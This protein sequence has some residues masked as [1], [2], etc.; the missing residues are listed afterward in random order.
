M[1]NTDVKLIINVLVLAFVCS[2][3]VAEPPVQTFTLNNFL[4]A[5]NENAPGYGFTYQSEC[6]S[7]G[8]APD[9]TIYFDWWYSFYLENNSTDHAIVSWNWIEIIS[10]TSWWEGPVMPGIHEGT[11]VGD[12]YGGANDPMPLQPASGPSI[13]LSHRRAEDFSD[14]Y[15][16]VELQSVIT[17]DDGHTE[18]VPIY[19]PANYRESMGGRLV[20]VPEPGSIV[21]IASGLIGLVGLVGRKRSR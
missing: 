11:F 21:D 1:Q 16:K 10:P 13:S 14:L 2:A 19:V 12:P 7:P 9:G 8:Q 5:P 17:W 6:Q 15:E 3:A 20:V 4:T 18:Q